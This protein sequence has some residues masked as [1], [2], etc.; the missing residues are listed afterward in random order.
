[1][2]LLELDGTPPPRARRI[3]LTVVHD[4]GYR[5]PRN[6]FPFNLLRNVAPCAAFRRLPGSHLV[7]AIV[8]LINT[9]KAGFA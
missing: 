8:S 7:A 1:M 9:E 5:S 6:R 4:E 2:A 3:T